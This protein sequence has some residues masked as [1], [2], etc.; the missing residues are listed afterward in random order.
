MHTVLLVI[1]IV[2]LVL[3]V[4]LF[5][6]GA[7]YAKSSD[8]NKSKDAGKLKTSGIV[9]G[10]IGLIGAVAA[11]AFGDQIHAYTGGSSGKFY[12]F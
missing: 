11:V 10:V 6:V 5:A 2:L 1:G 12:Y 4:I 7:S 9:V 3:G 8:K